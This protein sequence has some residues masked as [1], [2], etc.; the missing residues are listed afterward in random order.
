MK[1]SVE[2][3]DHLEKVGSWNSFREEYQALHEKDP[4]YANTFGGMLE[5]CRGLNIRE[6]SYLIIGG[7]AVASYLHQADSHAFRDWRGTSDI[8]LMVPDKK[9]AEEVLNFADYKFRQTYPSKIGMKGKLYNYAKDNQGETIVVGLREGIV[10]S[11]GKDITN[12]LLNH[13]AIIPVHGVRIAVPQ[14]K[15]LISMK[16]FAN[17]KKDRE[18]LNFLK[19]VFGKNNLR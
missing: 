10:N 18:D 16:R 1:F 15:D 8:D 12:K 9:L 3:I 14:W 2:L 5:I 19:T 4:A 17:R 6:T 7:M 13:A 11:S